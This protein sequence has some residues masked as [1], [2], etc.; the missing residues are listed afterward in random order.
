M[1]TGKNLTIRYGPE[2]VLRDFNFDIA[3]NQHTIFKGD[4]GSGKTTLLK[5]LLHFVEPTRGDISFKDDQSVRALREHSAW[6]P[7]DLDL[8]E[9][10]VEEVMRVP[11]TF[12]ANHST[13]PKRSRMESALKDLGVN[14]NAL[15][16]PFRNLSTGQCQRVGLALCH[17]LDKP[18]L[19][20]DEP[21]SA[22]DK[23]SKQKV[24]ELLIENQPE[25]TVISTSH[26]PD[27]I[28]TAD[29]IIEL[30]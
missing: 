16:K 14:G 13:S 20:L 5:M 30:D 11:F 1:L 21:T 29:Q 9:G 4:S 25:H 12:A 26:D 18:V 15:D 7:Q 27:W 28:E 10:T 24:Y 8:G 23:T 2:T 19:L 22:L 17:L 6:L 3:P